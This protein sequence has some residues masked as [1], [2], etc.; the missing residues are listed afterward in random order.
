MPLRHHRPARLAICLAAALTTTAHADDLL[1]QAEQLLSQKK[2]SEAY[3]L[4]APLED[5]RGGSPDY[6]LLLGRAAIASGRHTEAAFALE[7]C[8]A[9][10]PK[11]GPCRMEMAQ[12]HMLLGE[13]DSARI[14]LKTIQ[15]YNPPAEVQSVVSQYM[16]LLQQQEQAKERQV[17]MH[18]QF[19]LGY[20]SNVN[21]ATDQRQVA[22]PLFANLLFDLDSSAREQDDA[23]AQLEAG[24]RL[25][26]TLNPTWSLLADATVNQRLYQDIDALNALI[27]DAGVGTAWR[28][29][30]NQVVLKAGAQNYQLDGDDYRQI[31]NG[32]A[33]YLFSPSDS[34]QLSTYV[35]VADISY[36][37]QP[38]RDARRDTLG[39]AWSQA[40]DRQYQPVVYAGLY[41]GEENADDSDFDRF[42]NRFVG[43][44]LGGVIHLGNRLQ[45]TTSASVE[46]RQYEEDEI[47][48]MD[49]REDT[50]VDVSLGLAYRLGNHLSI[51]PT[52]TYTD[53]DSNI[54]INDFT[55]HMVSVDIRYER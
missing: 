32:M 22:I 46:D 51:R 38:H 18:A 47:L 19:G 4:L 52:Y 41:G 53:N 15:D 28:A 35:Q 49:T 25:R 1:L 29:G 26:Q 42:S 20:D 31:I 39:A 48:F 30:A 9:M 16:G 45:L 17:V 2:G 34:S 7:R 37:P 10:D 36:D 33:Q 21:S 3:A 50:Q 55:R 8:L 40:L 27:L 44:R 24:V 12:A 54:V 23:Y 5:E 11:N 6:D 43:L 13:T 14:E